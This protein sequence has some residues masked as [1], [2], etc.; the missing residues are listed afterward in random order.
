M[1]LLR[2]R[3]I[4]FYLQNPEEKKDIGF[5]YD[6]EMLLLTTKILLKLTVYGFNKPYQ[7]PEVMNFIASIFERVKTILQLSKYS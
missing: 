6:L 3:L 1:D 7:S 2:H 5:R 4:E